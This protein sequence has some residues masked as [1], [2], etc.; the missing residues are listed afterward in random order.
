[1][2]KK[3]KLRR[4]Y[5]CIMKFTMGGVD[6]AYHADLWSKCAKRKNG[7]WEWVGT[8]DKNGYG[9]TKA[10]GKTIKPHRISYAIA[11][12]DFDQSFYVCHKCDNPSCIN[13]DHLFLGTN[14]DNQKDCVRKGRKPNRDGENHPLAI[15]SDSDVL[16]IR[17]R[18]KRRVVTAIMLAKEYG[19][20]RQQVLRIIHGHR[21]GHI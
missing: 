5:A 19:V 15:L 4:S 7:C 1:M 17:A 16:Q 3:K 6:Y 10:N 8:K 11:N 12:G 21:W 9:K 14:S 13:P 20:S 2:Q 18:Y